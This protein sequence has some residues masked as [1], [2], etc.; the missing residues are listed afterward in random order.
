MA[1]RHIVVVFKWIID[2]GALAR[3]CEICKAV[4]GLGAIRCFSAAVQIRIAS[5]FRDTCV[6][7][8]LA[9]CAIAADA[10]DDSA[11][12]PSGTITISYAFTHLQL[13]LDARVQEVVQQGSAM[14]HATESLVDPQSHSSPYST[15]LLPHTEPPS[16]KQK[17]P[18]LDDELMRCQN[19][20]KENRKTSTN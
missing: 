11:E 15:M 2:I 16:V 9:R 18:E 20:Y 13:A 1:T 14:A 5:G 19:S 17:P 10:S 6:A 3:K 8:R 12:G 7:N 4:N